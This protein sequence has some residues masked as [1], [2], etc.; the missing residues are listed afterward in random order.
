MY[1]VNCSNPIVVVVYTY[2]INKKGIPSDRVIQLLVFVF[3]CANRYLQCFQ[4]KLSSVGYKAG[5]R[6]K[7]YN[8]SANTNTS[9]PKVIPIPK[10]Y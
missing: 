3:F 1:T 8:I 4:F 9:E 6:L 7:N 2:N 10:E 5:Y